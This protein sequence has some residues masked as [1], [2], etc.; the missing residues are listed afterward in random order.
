M[1]GSNDPIKKAFETLQGDTLPN[2]QQKDRILKQILL[3]VNE[4]DRDHIERLRR[5]ITIY[6]WRFAFGVSAVQS[7]IFTLVFGNNYTH[8]IL[9]LFGG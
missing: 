4:Y 1:K 3:Q 9:R 8:L 7:I 2:L 5:L 6:P